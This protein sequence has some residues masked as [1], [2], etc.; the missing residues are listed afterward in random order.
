MVDTQAE[1]LAFNSLSWARQDLAHASV[2]RLCLDWSA[3]LEIVHESGH[4]APAQVVG[5]GETAAEVVFVPGEVPS[6]GYRGF[7]L[8]QAQRPAETSLRVEGRRIESR[9]YILELADDGAIARL[10]DKRVGREVLMEDQPANDLRLF[11]DG[12]E[13]EAAWNVHAT[14]SKRQYEWDPG[15]T[16]ELVESGPVRATVRITKTYRQS[17]LVQDLVLY[18]RLPR[19]DFCTRVHWDERQVML[20]AAFPVGVRASEATY[21]IQFGAIQRPTHSNTSWEQEKFEVCAHRWVDLSEAGYGVSLL[22]D[23]KYGHDVKGNVLRLTLLRGT[24]SPDPDADRGEHAFTYA[25][26]PHVGDW[27]EAETVRRAAELNTPLV[28]VPAA[29]GTCAVGC[30]RELPPARSFISVEGPAI[31]ETIKLAEDADG[32]ILRLYEPH[33]GRGRVRVCV[34]ETLGAVCEC[35]HVEE[36]LADVVCESS[37]FG[38]SIE[39]FQVRSFRVH[40]V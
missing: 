13:G 5:C 16:V 36:Y 19:I 26:L 29:G 7:S 15:T 2:P 23:C 39:P 24:E 18:D 17:R 20:K 34:E 9:F 30:G 35:N 10:F 11:Q 33:G 38:F 6:L 32:W 12:P 4:T 27:R 21:E 37:S 3:P 31:L 22:N 40:L 14:F 28:C 8:R 25:L 1:M